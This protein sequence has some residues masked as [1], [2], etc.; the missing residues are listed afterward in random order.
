MAI[1]LGQNYF[2]TVYEEGKKVVWPTRQMVIKHTGM[3]IV[4]VAISAAVFTGID[5]GFQQLVL[6]SITR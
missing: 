1:N 2:R 4:V 3:V 6:I 5:Y